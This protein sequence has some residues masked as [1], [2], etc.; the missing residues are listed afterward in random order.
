MAEPP[1]SMKF[2]TKAHEEFNGH[3]Y[4]VQYVRCYLWYVRMRSS[5]HVVL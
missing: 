1:R 5:H 2:G 3:F 4:T